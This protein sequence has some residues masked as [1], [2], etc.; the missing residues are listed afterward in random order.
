MK[1][2][3]MVKM[4]LYMERRG[5]SEFAFASLPKRETGEEGRKLLTQVF[6]SLVLMNRR[7]RLVLRL[8]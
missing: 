6:L 7:V 3:L 2:L 8:R 4:S 1:V 5:V